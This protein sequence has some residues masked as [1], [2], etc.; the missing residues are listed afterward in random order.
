MKKVFTGLSVLR[1]VH[2]Y[3]QTTSQTSLKIQFNK[4]TLS[5]CKQINTSGQTLLAN[6]TLIAENFIKHI[7]LRLQNLIYIF[8]R[9]HLSVSWGLQRQVHGVFSLTQQKDLKQLLAELHQNK[10]KSTYL[11]QLP[12]ELVCGQRLASPC[13]QPLC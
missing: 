4:E 13:L 6:V 11:Q 5:L 1:N 10:K 7:G 8:D 12:L 3:I 2:V 9:F